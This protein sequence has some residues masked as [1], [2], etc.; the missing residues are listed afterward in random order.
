[1][2]LMIEWALG[3]CGDE[4]DSL[5][6]A[7][8]FPNPFSRAKLIVSISGVAMNPRKSLF[9]IFTFTLLSSGVAWSLD[10]DD[11]KGQLCLLY[12]SPSPRD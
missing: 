7:I 4:H 3:R 9:A 11:A 1:M 2:A 10:D 8:G 12:T 6:S 5:T